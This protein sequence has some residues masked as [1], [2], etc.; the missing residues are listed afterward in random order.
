MLASEDVDSPE[1]RNDGAMR[2]G[3]FRRPGDP[4]RSAPQAALRV[5]RRDDPGLRGSG[6][7]RAG[8]GVEFRGRVPRNRGDGGCWLARMSTRRSDE[9]TEPCVPDSSDAPA[10]QAAPPRR[11]PFGLADGMILVAAIAVG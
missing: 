2:P 8:P 1:R 5:G 3:L 6:R 7:C 9:M 10:I 11:R 4:G